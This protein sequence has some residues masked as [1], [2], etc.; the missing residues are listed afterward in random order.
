MPNT[1]EIFLQSYYVTQG[2]QNSSSLIVWSNHDWRFSKFRYHRYLADRYGRAPHVYFRVFNQ[3]EQAAGT[4]LAHF[5][6]YQKRLFGTVQFSDLARLLLLRNYGGVWTDS[7]NI[8]LRPIQKL[9]QIAP[10]GFPC[11]AD[12][13]NN[14]V[15]TV[16]NYSVATN[17]LNMACNLTDP[18]L[19]SV[20]LGLWNDVLLSMCAERGCGMKGFEITLVDPLWAGSSNG[21]YSLFFYCDYTF[22]SFDDLSRTYGPNGP[23][24]PVFSHARALNKCARYSELPNGS[25]RLLTNRF[26]YLFDNMGSIPP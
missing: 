18:S 25:H 23:I 24:D 9:L 6:I 22:T 11:F 4:C 16:Q 10:N 20:N 7:D 2:T 1:F 19:Y 13:V 3:D 12:T 21:V 8:F 26:Q 5:K 15:L 14:N 17:L